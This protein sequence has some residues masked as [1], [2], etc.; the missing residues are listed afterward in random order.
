MTYQN[1]SQGEPN[2][3]GEQDACYMDENGQWGDTSVDSQHAFV[4]VIDPSS[5]KFEG[6]SIQTK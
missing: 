2:N 4:C 1:W 3:I 5:S 6:K